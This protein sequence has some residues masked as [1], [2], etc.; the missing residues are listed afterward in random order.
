MSA[1]PNST[2]SAYSAPIVSKAMRVLRMI[3]TSPRN[4]GI[5]EIAL[6]LSLAK[7]T[8]HGILAALE[9]TGWVLRD[10][11]T[12]KYTSGYTAKDIAGKADIRLP[13][14]DKV[15]PH[16]KQLAVELDEDIFLGIC[17]G[18][19]LLII[20]QMESAKELK[21]TARPGT[22]LPLFAGAAGKIFL[23]HQDRDTVTR[24]VRSKP[25]PQFT[26]KS[27]TD[28]RL[29]LEELRRVRREGIASDVAEYLTNVWCVALPIFYGK[30]NRRRMVAGFWVV[31]INSA[32]TSQRMQ[33]AERLGRLTG[34]AITRAISHYNHDEGS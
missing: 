31:G 6:K 28:P 1:K 30:K 13:L 18:N 27:I 8:T 7:S 26:Q 32:L 4:P 29:Y 2:H 22:R 20:D 11:V 23:A 9:E 3:V 25:I 19:H 33:T 16:L 24:L 34:D 21:I 15:R 10:P 14:V 5:S 12:R 17:T